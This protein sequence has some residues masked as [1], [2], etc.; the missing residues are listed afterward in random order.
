MDYIKKD[1][2]TQE[3]KDRTIGFWVATDKFLSGWGHAPRRSLVACPVFDNADSEAVEL[4]FIKRN[5]FKYV[6]FVGEDYRPKL[7][8]GDHLH[9]YNGKSF[10]YAL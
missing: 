7:Y 2:R 10:R 9:I 6:R 1:D 8:A 5:E 4:R 3:E